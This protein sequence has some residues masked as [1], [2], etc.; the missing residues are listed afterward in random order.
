VAETARTRS[1][2]YQTICTDVTLLA[3]TPT[4]GTRLYLGSGPVA[5]AFPFGVMQMLAG[6]NDLNAIGAVRIWSDMLWLVKVVTKGT[7]SGAIEPIVNRIDALLHAAS[8]TVTNGVIHTCIRE[9]P[10]ELPT[11]EDG[12]AYIQIGAE[13]RIKASNA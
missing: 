12:V 11:V 13:Y 1:W 7:S 10:F 2:L 3:L 9:R 5:A 6:G 4:I 8:G